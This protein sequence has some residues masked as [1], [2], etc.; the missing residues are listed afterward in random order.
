MIEKSRIWKQSATTLTEEQAAMEEKFINRATEETESCIESYLRL[1]SS[2]NGHYISSDLFKEVFPEFIESMEA[3]RKF[4]TVVHNSAAVLA[5]E[6]FIRNARDERIKECVFLTGVPGAGK[7]FFIQSL[8]LSGQ[9][10]E[11]IMIFEG[12]ITNESIK[13]KI[14]LVIENNKSVNIIVINPTLELAMENAINRALEMGRGASCSTMAR[15]ISSLPM[16]L[17]NIIRMC[18]GK[19]SL[20]IYNKTANDVIDYCLGFNNLYLLQYGTYEEIK[21]RLEAIRL[22]ILKKKERVMA[23]QTEYAS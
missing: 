6:L 15:I 11:D 8:Y 4:A 17:D 9:I 23:Y 18:D 13:E 22:E 21:A 20:G 19:L 1:P 2:M 16:A 14:K 10:P 7:T 5:N 12:D 3:R